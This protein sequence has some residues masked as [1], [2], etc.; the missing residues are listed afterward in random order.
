MLL[1]DHKEVWSLSMKIHRAGDLV[2]PRLKL[3]EIAKFSRNELLS[4]HAVKVIEEARQN[5]LQ[6][7]AR[8]E[9][10]EAE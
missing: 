8:P 5:R 3:A 7:R 10:R 1:E 9:K 6:N 2:E 4:R